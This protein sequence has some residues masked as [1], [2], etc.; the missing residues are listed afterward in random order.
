MGYNGTT[1]LCPGVIA[2]LFF[3]CEMVSS[4]F[5]FS[6]KNTAK[7]DLDELFPLTTPQTWGGAPKLTRNSPETHQKLTRNS[8]EIH[9]N[10]TAK[11]NTKPNG[12]APNR[13]WTVRVWRWYPWRRI[14]PDLPGSRNRGADRADRGY[15]VIHKDFMEHKL[16]IT[17]IR[18][19]WSMI[20]IDILYLEL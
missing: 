19:L 11:P 1:Y 8:P 20:F 15:T 3:I 5:F 9:Q 12:A 4:R 14:R 10:Q 13:N 6:S 18:L 7:N 17:I 16:V 2:Y